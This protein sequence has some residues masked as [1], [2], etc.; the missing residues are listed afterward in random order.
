MRKAGHS[1]NAHAASTERPAVKSSA[2]GSRR[3]VASPGMGAPPKPPATAS[4]AAR[5]RS[6]TPA[7]A[8]SAPAAPPAAA[9]SNASVTCERTRSPRP[10]PSA[11]RTTRSRRRFSAR[12]V[13]RLATFAHA[14]R[15]TMPTV[16]SRIHSARRDPADQVLAQRLHHRPVTLHD[17]HVRRRTAE[18]L[19]HA[20][21]ERFELR[22]DRC[23]IRCPAPGARPRAARTRRA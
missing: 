16:P 22:D 20:T 4:G 15:N 8:M 10:A 19:L 6:G 12:T 17:P 7:H 3:A 18:P 5:T 13:N 2:A 11:R 1:P 9:R 23:A 21:R 14:M